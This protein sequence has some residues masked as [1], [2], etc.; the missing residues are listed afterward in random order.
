M[1]KKLVSIVVP[2]YNAEN[3]IEETV[4]SVFVQTYRPLE[5]IVINDGSTDSTKSII[6]NSLKSAP[7]KIKIN[8][9]DLKENKGAANALNLGFSVAGGDYICW[10]SADDMFIDKD[11]TEKQISHMIRTNADWGYLNNFYRGAIPSKAR[12]VKSKWLPGSLG[13]TDSIFI[14]DPHLR[15]ILL[16]FRNPINGSSIMIR[17]KCIERYGQFDPILKNIGADGDLWMRYSVLER[18][19]IATGGTSIFYRKSSIQ[20][21]TNKKEMTYGSELVR[22]R[23]MMILQKTDKLLSLL[24]KSNVLLP[25]IFHNKELYLKTP[26]TS[27]LLC[28]YI[29]KNKKFFNPILTRSARKVLSETEKYLHNVNFNE[30]NFFKD[31]QRRMNSPVYQNFIKLIKS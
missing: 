4:R 10:L 31:L 18:K 30:S 16:F 11:K 19:L 6:E 29:L 9:I 17:K 12:L 3:F 14:N 24:Q 22:T 23:V 27:N 13:F 8:I 25:V 7:S 5:I 2:A 20:E 15:L 28:K 1:I 21:S 26:F